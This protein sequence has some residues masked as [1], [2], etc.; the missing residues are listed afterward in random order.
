[1]DGRSV[2]LLLVDDE[3]MVLDIGI[4]MLE[5]MGYQVLG[6]RSSTEAVDVFRKHNTSI[7]VVLL[8]YM[9]PDASGAETFKKIRKINPDARVVLST[10]HGENQEILD[11]MKLGCRGMIQKLFGFDMLAEKIKRAMA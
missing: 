6:A 10:G 5:R 4:M 9:L 3:D 2:C 8:D 7:D 1:M 11:L